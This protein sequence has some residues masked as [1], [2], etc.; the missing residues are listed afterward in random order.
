ML[1]KFFERFRRITHP[2]VAKRIL[3]AA[4]PGR[5]ELAPV[6]E[7]LGYRL[8][9][10][11]WRA[12]WITAGGTVLSSVTGRTPDEAM[13]RLLAWLRKRSQGLNAARPPFLGMRGRAELPELGVRSER[14]T[15]RPRGV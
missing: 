4:G 9:K 14:R 12:L 8:T 1:R 5:I 3:T 10:S 7:W 15:G 11:R 6:T 13:A 2:D